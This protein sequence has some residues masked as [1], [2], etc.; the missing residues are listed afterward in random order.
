MRSMRWLGSCLATLSVLCGGCGHNGAPAPATIGYANATAVYVMGVPITPDTPSGGGATSYSV[1][2]ALPAGLSLNAGTG[3]ISGTPSS[4]TAKASYTVTAAGPGGNTTTTLTITV[5]DQSP[6]Q[7]SYAAGTATYIVNAPI[8]E[9]DPSSAG[10][11]VT[12]YTVNPALPAGLSLS[13]TTG[14]ITGTPTTLT[15]LAKYTVTATN[16]GGTAIAVLAI[17]VS[18]ASSAPLAA[19]AGLAYSTGNATY[20]A[21][22]AIPANVPSSTGGVPL[23]YTDPSGNPVPA[24]SISR[25]SPGDGLRRL[26]ASSY[27][28]PATGDYQRN[29]CGCFAADPIQGNGQQSGRSTTASLIIEVN[30]ADRLRRASPTAHRR[31]V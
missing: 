24:Y 10:G 28:R 25:A 30:A 26:C 9:N 23:P 31:R 4:V 29:A 15:P 5:N 14:D 1:S 27:R 16:T 12:S 21:G 20:T 13:T 22:V 18:P 17:T 7:F 2:P 8:T 3:I 19:P 6:T 11:A